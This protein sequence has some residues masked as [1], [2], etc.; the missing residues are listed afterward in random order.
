M[1]APC[2]VVWWVY[3]RAYT[4]PIAC[5]ERD[6]VEHSYQTTWAHDVGLVVVVSVKGLRDRTD[7]VKEHHSMEMLLLL[8]TM[9]VLNGS[10]HGDAD[11]DDGG[12]CCDYCACCGVYCD[13]R[14]WVSDDDASS[15]SCSVVVVVEWWRRKACLRLNAST[16]CLLCEARTSV[17]KKD[18]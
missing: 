9:L 7:D 2:E 5:T 4:Q 13:V 8:M 16:A 6:E 14:V 10:C 18:Q 17:L 1:C 15:S 12:D 3:T 11:A